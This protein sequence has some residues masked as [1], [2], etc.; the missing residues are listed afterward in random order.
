[1]F[2]ANF[3]E[4]EITGAQT[5]FLLLSPTSTF[6]LFPLHSRLLICLFFHCH[7]AFLVPQILQISRLFEI[8]GA[9]YLAERRLVRL[10]KYPTYR[11]FVAVAG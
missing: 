11:A 9:F 7:V 4:E 5:T 10:D 2:A 1:M 6:R 8:C 3:G